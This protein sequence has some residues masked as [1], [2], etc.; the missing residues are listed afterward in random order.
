VGIFFFLMVTNIGGVTM[1]QDMKII[2][3]LC[4]LALAAVGVKIHNDG[5]PQD[6]L[7]DCKRAEAWV[8]DWNGNKADDIEEIELSEYC[9][10]LL[11]NHQDM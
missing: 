5:L 11:Q 7:V 10:A 6:G 3:A 8:A 9:N 2:I 4:V 1:N